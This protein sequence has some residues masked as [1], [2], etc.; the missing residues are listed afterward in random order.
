MVFA[1]RAEAVAAEDRH[2]VSAWTEV[3]RF[4]E[5]AASH[6][7]VPEPLLQVEFRDAA[8]ALDLTT[9]KGMAAFARRFWMS[10]LALAVRL[11][12]SRLITPGAYR[13]WKAKWDAYVDAL[14]PR[15]GGPSSPAQKTMG[16][17]GRP[18]VQMV[19]EAM[20][21]NRISSLQ[22]TRYLDL[23]LGHFQELR[24]RAWTGRVEG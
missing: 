9:A 15:K 6:A 8:D 12:E 22:A 23:G 20:E 13:D 7:F 14:P 1:G 17:C 10:P 18:F 3:E 4:A 21:M 24:E 2:S 11:R 5:V 16:R 19:I